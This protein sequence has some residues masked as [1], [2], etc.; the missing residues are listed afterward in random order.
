MYV[1]KLKLRVNNWS[2]FY[3]RTTD[4][5]NA[6]SKMVGK[7]MRWSGWLWV[8]LDVCIV[9]SSLAISDIEIVRLR[10][11]L[12]GLHLSCRQ[13]QMFI[14]T[15]CV[16]CMITCVC[17]FVFVHVSYISY[18]DHK[19]KIHCLIYDAYT[20]NGNTFH[21]QIFPVY[22]LSTQYNR[23]NHKPYS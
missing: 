1:I 19:W 15:N 21:A 14:Y 13:S 3:T 4:V 5:R 20:P 23:N 8:A 10:S 9:R 7:R 6:S 11:G 2:R 22:P 17:V 16:F 12:L 18:K